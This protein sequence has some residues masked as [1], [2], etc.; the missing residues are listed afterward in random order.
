M[1]IN[2]QGKGFVNQV[3]ESLHKMTGAEQR[4]TSAYHPKSG[5]L[6]ECQNRSIKDSLIKLLEGFSLTRKT[7]NT[8]KPLCFTVIQ[9]SFTTFELQTK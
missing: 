5:G 8:T 9:C 1:E 6:C 4:I 7:F 3:A 2:D